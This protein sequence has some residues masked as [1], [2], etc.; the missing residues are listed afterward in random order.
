MYNDLLKILLEK[1]DIDFDSILTPPSPEEFYERNKNT[2]G[3]NLSKSSI[4]DISFLSN[5]INFKWLDLNRNLISDISFLSKLKNIEKLDLS[6]NQISD[7]S[8]LFNLKNLKIVHFYKN[9][10]DRDD[11]IK[12]KNLF[13]GIKIYF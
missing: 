7:I 3:V 6:N 10:I 13:S 5:L 9:P 8:P 12:L 2:T 11:I 1:Q 4:S